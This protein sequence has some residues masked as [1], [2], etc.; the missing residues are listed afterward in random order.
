MME[1]VSPLSLSSLPVLLWSPVPLTC[2]GYGLFPKSLRR[3][4]A[5]PKFAGSLSRRRSSDL[6]ACVSSPNPLEIVAGLSIFAT[7]APCVAS[8]PTRVSLVAAAAGDGSPAR[9]HRGPAILARCYKRP[10]ALLQTTVRLATEGRRHCYSAAGGAINSQPT[11]LQTSVRAATEGRRLCY[12]QPSATS[13]GRRCCCKS[14]ADDGLLQAASA[15]AT[16]LGCSCYER[17]CKGRAKVAAAANCGRRCYK[18]WPP[19]L[20]GRSY[21]HG[22]QR[23]WRKLRAMMVVL[24]QVTAI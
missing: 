22:C 16:N 15:T 20:Q 19:V 18:L 17:R 8:P 23:P 10:S 5:L 11:L 1:T 3:R 2:H 21:D 6:P 24:R 7:P 13:A 4:G 14:V 12:K 9:R